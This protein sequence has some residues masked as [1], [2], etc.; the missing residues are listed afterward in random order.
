MS[1]MKFNSQKLIYVISK[2]RTE[3]WIKANDCIWQLKMHSNV[4]SKI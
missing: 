3:T 4:F 1:F 2:D